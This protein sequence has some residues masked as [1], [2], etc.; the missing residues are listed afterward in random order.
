MD[1]GLVH[2]IMSWKNLV[3]R[4]SGGRNSGIQMTQCFPWWKKNTDGKM[5]W[6]LSVKNNMPYSWRVLQWLQILN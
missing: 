3:F 2:Y 5:P 4:R 1:V 6:V